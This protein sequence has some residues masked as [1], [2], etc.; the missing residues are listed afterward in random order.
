MAS[1]AGRKGCAFPFYKLQKML[2]GEEYVSVSMVPMFIAGIC[3]TLEKLTAAVNNPRMV[4][5]RGL[6]EAKFQE[7]W[8]DGSPGTVFDERIRRGSRRTR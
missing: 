8:G 3:K 2:E 7:R 6:M 1:N 4:L 5:L